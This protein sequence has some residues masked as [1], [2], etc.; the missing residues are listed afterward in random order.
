MTK[1]AE[2]DRK[3]EDLGVRT[4][5]YLNIK[6]KDTNQWIELKINLMLKEHIDM[7]IEGKIVAARLM[8][9]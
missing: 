4:K 8:K 3:L 1:R 6:E 9:E 2:F 5:E 7:A